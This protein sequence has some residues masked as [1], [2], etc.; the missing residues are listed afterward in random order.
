[1]KFNRKLMIMIICA[2]AFVLV[3]STIVVAQ[4]EEKTAITGTVEQTD[5]GFV[6]MGEDGEDYYVAGKDLS[7]M[8]GKDVEAIGTVTENEGVKTLR[9][10]TVKEVE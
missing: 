10:I 6:I 4:E 5:T 2:L 7:A 3:G 1:M 8:I 9:L